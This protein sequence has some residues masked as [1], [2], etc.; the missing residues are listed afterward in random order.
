MK[1]HRSGLFSYESS[2]STMPWPR[3]SLNSRLRLIVSGPVPF[4]PGAR[5][6]PEGAAPHAPHAA[7]SESSLLD[8]WFWLVC[9]FFGPG[10]PGRRRCFPV[11][12]G[13]AALRVRPLKILV[14]AD[15]L[16]DQVVP[17]DV[18]LSKLHNADAFDFAAHFQRFDQAALLSLRQVD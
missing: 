18:L 16:L 14:G 6:I 17:D 7:G 3:R 5:T 4:S 11:G 13:Y 8:F 15:N 12:V 2:G 9:R 10:F 1:A